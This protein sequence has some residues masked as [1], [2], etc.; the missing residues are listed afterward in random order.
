[1]RFWSAVLVLFAALLSSGCPPRLIPDE[2]P[3]QP[4]V[5]TESI[6][7]RPGRGDM[8]DTAGNAQVG[9][10][11]EMLPLFN[12]EYLPADAFPL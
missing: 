2:A 8:L 5:P 9:L 11:S 6:L 3:E 12:P 7:I 4:E 10:T 1:M